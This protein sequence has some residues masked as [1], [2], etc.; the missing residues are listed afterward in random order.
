MRIDVRRIAQIA[1]IDLDPQDEEAMAREL[2][3]L[4]WHVWTNCSSLTW[5]VCLP[6]LL[7]VKVPWSRLRTCPM[8]ASAGNW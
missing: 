4:S 5:R 6:P 3:F 2:R 8:R 1:R 7:W